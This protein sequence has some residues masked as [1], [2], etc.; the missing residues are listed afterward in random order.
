[1]NQK[2]TIRDPKNLSYFVT[3]HWH[4]NLKVKTAQCLTD[5]IIVP[6]ALSTFGQK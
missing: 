6:T 4:H 3:Q 2:T 1:M 5:S